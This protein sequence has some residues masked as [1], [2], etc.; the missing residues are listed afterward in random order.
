M[1]NSLLL[2]SKK[3]PWRGGD[4]LGQER[5]WSRRSS[6]CQ[7]ARTIVVCVWPAFGW[8]PEVCRMVLHGDRIQAVERFSPKGRLA[9]GMWFRCIWESSRLR[10]SASRDIGFPR[11]LM[12]LLSWGDFSYWTMCWRMR[13]PTMQPFWVAFGQVR[14]T[15]SCWS[16]PARTPS[17]GFAQSQC[18]K[19]SCSLCWK[20][21]GSIWYHDVWSRRPT[22]SSVS[23]MMRHEEARVICPLIGTSWSFVLLFGQRS[24]LRPCPPLPFAPLAPMDGGWS[25]A[26]CWQRLASGLSP[27]PFDEPLGCI[28]VFRHDEWQ[29][30]AFQIYSSLLFGLPLAVTSFN[31]YSRFAEAF[32]RRLLRCLVSMYYDDAHLTDLDSNGKSSQWAFGALNALLGTPFAEEK[33]QPLSDKGTFLGLDYDFTE[34]WPTSRVFFWA[35]ERLESQVVTMMKDARSHALWGF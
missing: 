30:P 23:S 26:G 6:W 31:C 8:W 32:G 1:R 20:D 17:M 35:R 27:L 3:Q 22:G 15:P 19:Q 9:N 29:Q 28:V 24:T 2:P 34:I 18:P 5:A 14:T 7:A 13:L 4:Y 25:L 33:W 16:S 12:V 21:G 11:L 10:Q